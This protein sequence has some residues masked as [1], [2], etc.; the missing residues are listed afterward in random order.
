MPAGSD[1]LATLLVKIGAD[2]SEF[3]KTLGTAEQRL[4]ATAT[5]MKAIGMELSLAV[6][7]P[8]AAAGGY[9]LKAA[10]DAYESE[11]KFTRAMGGMAESARAFSIGMRDQL[12]LNDFAIR[13]NIGTLY[14]M[15]S[16]MGLTA[17]EAY[18]MATS[19]TKLSYDLSSL[20]NEKP[21]EIFAK[22]RSGISGEAE[23]LKVLGILV[24]EA[25]TKHELYRRGIVQVGTELT[26]Q[27]KIQGRYLAIMRQSA[28]AHNNLADTITSPANQLRI[29]R[30]QINLSAIELGQSLLP[31]LESAMPIIRDVADMV[32]YGAEAFA[33]LDPETR[34]AALG[35][36]AV[37]AV[38][39]PVL[40]VAGSYL[41]LGS[42]AVGAV[43]GMLKWLGPAGQATKAAGD[44][45][46]GIGSATSALIK[47]EARSLALKGSLVLLAAGIGWMIGDAIRPWVN[48]LLGLNEAL[49]LIADK[50]KDFVNSLASDE[51]TFR[52]AFEQY[53][54]LRE[55]LG[56]TGE[57]WIVNGDQ[58]E[59]VGQG[60]CRAP[61]G[62]PGPRAAADRVSAFERRHEQEPPGHGHPQPQN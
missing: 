57:A 47:A 38:S 10:I 2:A 9:A 4:A 52:R 44:L 43:G 20:V 33:K 40:T 61:P 59:R 22:L 29:M 62:G 28:T 3:G 51:G 27:E 39:G 24:D 7:L 21:E 16:A 19:L 35:I 45:A 1:T 5:K 56:L 46:G 23:P 13:D 53:N 48:E 41:K 37:I 60:T 18:K 14:L 17:D 49:D 26:N 32:R 42:A 31:A 11:D 25:T 8:L 12:G 54:Q 55:Q 36:A 50:D 30:E 6:S 34:K 58:V 15:L